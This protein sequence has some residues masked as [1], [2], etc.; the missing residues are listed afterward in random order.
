MGFGK[1]TRPSSKLQS[2][3]SSPA[4]FGPPQPVGEIVGRQRPQNLGAKDRR[5]IECVRLDEI[6][7]KGRQTPVHAFRI[8]VYDSEEEE[9]E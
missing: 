2:V 1:V 5:R 7:V 8:D 6:M 4:P 9:G 3:R